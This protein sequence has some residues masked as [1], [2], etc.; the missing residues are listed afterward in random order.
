M[1]ECRDGRLYT[2]ITTDIARRL[3]EHNTGHRGAHFTRANPPVRLLAARQVLN[4]SVALKL[5]AGLK[6]LSRAQ[7]QRWAAENQVLGAV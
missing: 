4:R 2:G 3:T 6:K 7:K 1:L 5:E